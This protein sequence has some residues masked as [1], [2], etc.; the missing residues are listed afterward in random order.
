MTTRTKNYMKSF[1]C[2]I[3][4]SVNCYFMLIFIGKISYPY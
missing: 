4:F 1:Y 2:I 3:P